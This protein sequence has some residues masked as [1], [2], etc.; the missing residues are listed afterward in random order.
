MNTFLT[1]V[2]AMPAAGTAS[3]FVVNYKA[4][5]L[6]NGTDD[7]YADSVFQSG[8][9]L[10]LSFQSPV[11]GFIAVYLLD[12]DW[13]ASCLLPYQHQQEGIYAVMANQHYVFFNRSQAPHDDADE[14]VMTCDR[15][16]E[17]NEVYV[18]FSPNQFVKA[19]DYASERTT[20][21][22]GTAGLP[23]ELNSADFQRWLDACQQRDGSMVVKRFP[24][25]LQK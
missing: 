19:L 17:R 25:V 6:R 13:L 1:F 21:Q 14:Y 10:Y 2:V 8:D 22:A 11:S 23:R 9:A 24:I 18:V 4:Q 12:A 5:L 16:E 7:C 15:D 20:T 3:S